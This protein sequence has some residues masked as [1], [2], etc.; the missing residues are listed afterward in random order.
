MR[1]T[2]S[3]SEGR[4]RGLRRRGAGNRYGRWGRA[5]EGQRVSRGKESRRQQGGKHNEEQRERGGTGSRLPCNTHHNMWVV[6]KT[7][8]KEQ[9]EREKRGGEETQSMSVVHVETDTQKHHEQQSPKGCHPTLQLRSPNNLPPYR[10]TPVTDHTR[11]T[12]KSL[13]KPII[14][15][16]SPAPRSRG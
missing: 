1:W 11:H 15:S 8:G 3:S 4:S 9:R 7:G 12:H 10:C 14:C 13:L 6:R 2:A 16:A 5:A